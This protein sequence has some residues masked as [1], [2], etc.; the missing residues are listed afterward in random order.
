MTNAGTVQK[1]VP[2]FSLFKY[3]RA[4]IILG[5][6]LP[7]KGHGGLGF[8]PKI[9][10]AAQPTAVVVAHGMTVGSGVVDHQN[11]TFLELRQRSFLSKFVGVFA[12]CTTT[13]QGVRFFAPSFPETEM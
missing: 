12:D 9:L 2:A 11:V 4:E 13:S 7:A 8:C 10:S 1:A 6:F 5:G 3:L